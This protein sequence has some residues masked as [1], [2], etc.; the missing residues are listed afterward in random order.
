MAGKMVTFHLRNGEQ[1][2]Y[3]GVTRLDTSRPL[4]VLVYQQE[5]LIAQ[6]A[7][8][9]IVRTIQQNMA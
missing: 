4:T 8:H 9:E 2:S 1:R 6:V 5:Q 3:K 7:K